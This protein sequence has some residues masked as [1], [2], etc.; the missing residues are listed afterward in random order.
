VV[1]AAIAGKARFDEMTAFFDGVGAGHTAGVW[2]ES[3]KDR[4]E[5]RAAYAKKIAKAAAAR[6]VEEA[7]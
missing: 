4:P 3:P 7:I 5:F 2:Q 1:N 6:N